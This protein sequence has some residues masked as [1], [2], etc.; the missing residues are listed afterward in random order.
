MKLST[1]VRYGLRAMIEL[2]KQPLNTY[3]S[4]RLLA[5]KQHISTKYLEQIASPLKSAGL[6][7]AIRGAEGGYRLA[8]PAD[9]ITAWDIC[10]VLD[11]P[12]KVI[13]C[14]EHEC[15]RKEFCAAYP[16]WMDMEKQVMKVLKSY[17]L[18]KL[19]QNEVHNTQVFCT[20]RK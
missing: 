9:K 17:S 12:A 5:E 13:N 3:V 6:I 8:R 10:D 2:A 18:K 20:K 15:E 14:L 1:K 19:A 16:I 4:L 11:S 7:D